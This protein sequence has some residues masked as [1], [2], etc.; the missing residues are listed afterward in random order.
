MT[1]L[2][3]FFALLCMV[4]LAQLLTGDAGAQ[5]EEIEGLRAQRDQVREERARAAADIDPLNAANEEL[6]AALQVLT[7]DLASRE[8]ALAATRSQLQKAQADVITA[9]QEVVAAQ[10]KIESLKLQRQ[11]QAINAYVQPRTDGSGEEVLSAKDFNEGAR[12]RALVAAVTTSQGDL[13]D[14]MRRAEEDL[15]RA[16]KRAERAQVD[17]EARQRLEVQQLS[18][19]TEAVGRQQQ[20]KAVLDARIA[21]FVA[22]VDGHRGDE[23]RLT[24]QIAGLIVEE[25][26][27]LAAI[28][29][30]KRI[31]EER[32]RIAA[33]E[34]RLAALRAAGQ[35][36]EE[37]AP[38]SRANAALVEAP[39]VAAVSSL[40]W[41]V[42]G[43]V[44]SG[45]GP[46]WG[47]MHNGLDIAANT[48]TPVLSSAPGTVLSAG[49]NG[50]FGNAVLI[51][52]GGGL[53]TLY[54]HLNTI[55]VS[56]GQSVFTGNSLGS[57]G[58][59]GSCTGPHLHFEVR[60]NGVPYNPRQYLG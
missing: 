42:Q 8:E 47:R 30:A 15:E 41:P 19:I 29:E 7:D 55:N 43:P 24:A 9:Q 54:A 39:T 57:V 46:R 12:R 17:I 48:G 33:E 56:K 11:E 60:V 23:D 49:P 1:R 59:T 28:A 22:E 2:R 35:L 18:E 27:R 37:P 21:E 5:T 25:E 32:R 51:N 38:P 13:L 36:T 45:F 58:C 34:A 40:N 53:V 52:H 50:D 14:Q 4:L 3:P 26:A 6:E 20:A 10:Q 31:A 16:V 44:T